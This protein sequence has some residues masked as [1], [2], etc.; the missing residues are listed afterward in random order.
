MELANRC[1][2]HPT[3]ER[4]LQGMNQLKGIVNSVNH[5]S[6]R[7]KLIKNWLKEQNIF[8][9][10]YLIKSHFQLIKT[11][12][13]F[14]RYLINTQLN[15]H[16]FVTQPNS[17][18]NALLLFLVNEQMDLTIGRLQSNGSA[19]KLIHHQHSNHN[20]GIKLTC[21]HLKMIQNNEFYSAQSTFKTQNQLFQACLQEPSILSQ[22]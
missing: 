4:K 1:L 11:S 17:T 16:Y 8:E 12:E 10:V 13:Y 18:I 2:E 19:L 14:F 5:K 15:F 9:K 7:N 6:E 21:I 20:S 22:F 3:L